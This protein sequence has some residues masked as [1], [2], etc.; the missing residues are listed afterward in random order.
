MTFDTIINFILSKEGGY[1]DDKDD[2]GGETNYGISKRQYS[3]LDIKNLSLKKAKNIYYKDYWVASSAPAMPI[4]IQLA[5]MD[6]AVNQGKANAAMM[7]QRCLKV[8][9]DGSIGAITLNAAHISDQD[10]LLLNF[11]TAR[12]MHYHGLGRFDKYGKG[13]MKRLFDVALESGCEL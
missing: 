3:T 11:L 7:L 12:A 8:K 13:W 9:A 2:P 10:N 6:S 5:Y 4:P 1:V